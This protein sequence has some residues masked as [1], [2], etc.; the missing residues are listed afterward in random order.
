MKAELKWKCSVLKRT[1]FND[2]TDNTLKQW[3]NGCMKA[4]ET[5]NECKKLENSQTRIEKSENM[6]TTD[7]MKQ[8]VIKELDKVIN[9]NMKERS[10]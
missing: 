5:E 3:S 4:L 6:A 7:E 10:H 1:Q 8:N 9:T 2:E